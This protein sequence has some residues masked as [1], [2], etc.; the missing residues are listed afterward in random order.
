MTPWEFFFEEGNGDKEELAEEIEKIKTVR[1]ST[2]LK[3]HRSILVPS[4]F[5]PKM[6][7]I[8]FAVAGSTEIARATV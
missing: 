6:K 2:D 1:F 7:K 8:Y 3:K 4:F 5:Y